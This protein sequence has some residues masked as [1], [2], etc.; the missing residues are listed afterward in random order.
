MLRTPKAEG[1]ARPRM[2][3][4]M[5]KSVQ[6]P[7]E[8]FLSCL[9]GLRLQKLYLQ[10][11]CQADLHY[12]RCHLKISWISILFFFFKCQ[13]CSKVFY[14]EIKKKKV[15]LWWMLPDESRDGCLLLCVSYLPESHL[16]IQLSVSW[17]R[18]VSLQPFA[19]WLIIWVPIEPLVA[20]T[21]E[22][23]DP[24]KSHR[25]LYFSLW[26]SGCEK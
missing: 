4:D 8:L 6:S 24:R 26:I 21:G 11:S 16:C 9:W 7:C 18:A 13:I 22:S 3:C 12:P 14:W 10:W 1:S 17:C 15:Y 5:N 25:L 2:R 23:P 19:S 20:S